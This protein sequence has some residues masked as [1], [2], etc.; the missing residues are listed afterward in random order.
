[1]RTF[2]SVTSI[3]LNFVARGVLIG[4]KGTK[5]GKFINSYQLF[6]VSPCLRASVVDLTFIPSVYSV[7]LCCKGFVLLVACLNITLPGDKGHIESISRQLTVT[8]TRNS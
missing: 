6:S 8:S 7:P 2:C 3:F 4:P 5:I 1:M